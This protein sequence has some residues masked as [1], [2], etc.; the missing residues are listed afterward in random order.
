[1]H[2]AAATL[3]LNGIQVAFK[4]FQQRGEHQHVHLITQ[5]ESSVQARRAEIVEKT[6]HSILNMYAEQA[7]D[8]MAE[9]KKHTAKIVKTKDAMEH[10]TLMSRLREIDRNLADIRMD[11]RTV[12]AQMGKLLT[13]LDRKHSN[14]A[15]D[16][17]EP[18]ALTEQTQP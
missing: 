8:Y 11:A 16:L 14:F 17:A 4:H 6:C 1:M 15:S 5:L 9:K 10:A 3:A 7:R 13:A 2:V 12:Y 18:L